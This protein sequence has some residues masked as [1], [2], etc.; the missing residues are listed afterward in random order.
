LAVGI[1]IN[2]NGRD[3]HPASGFDNAASDLTTVCDQ[4]FFEHLAFPNEQ[5]N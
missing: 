4:D 1:R 3:P 5:R 2:R